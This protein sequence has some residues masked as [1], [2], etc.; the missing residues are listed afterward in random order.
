MAHAR[1]TKIGRKPIISFG[2]ETCG[3]TRLPV[4][5]F[6]VLKGINELSVTL[7]NTSAPFLNPCHFY[8][9]TIH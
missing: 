7:E 8:W 9:P 5:P 3:R 4:R 1:D 2:D 6:Y